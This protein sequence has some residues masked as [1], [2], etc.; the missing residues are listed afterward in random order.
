MKIIP[1][2]RHIKNKVMDL[3]SSNIN[4]GKYA[5][6]DQFGTSSKTDLIPPYALIARAFIVPSWQSLNPNNCTKRITGKKSFYI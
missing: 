4:N 5:S 6:F 2:T 3:A 1:P